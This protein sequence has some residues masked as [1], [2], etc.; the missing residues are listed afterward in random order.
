LGAPPRVAMLMSAHAVALSSDYAAWRTAKI[1]ASYRKELDKKSRQLHRKGAIAFA[2]VSDPDTIRATL[3]QMR[4]YRG[5]RFGAG[6]LLQNPI[7]FDFYLEVAL[8]R[9]LARMY[10]VTLDS[11]PIAGVLG[12]AHNGR[13]LVILSAFDLANH[14][15]Q[16]LGSLTFELVAQHC[17]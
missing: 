8:Q 7:Y 15:N 6:D 16:S 10:S 12:L 5:P 9:S 11:V 14:K 1:S 2:C 13:F 3:E 17:I 4:A